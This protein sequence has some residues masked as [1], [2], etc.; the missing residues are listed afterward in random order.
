MFFFLVIS[1]IF[2][3]FCSW[4]KILIKKKPKLINKQ[5]GREAGYVQKFS[6]NT[7]TLVDVYL[8]ESNGILA[9]KIFINSLA[10][11]MALVDT[12]SVMRLFDLES[13]VQKDELAS[14]KRNDVWNVA[15]AAD[16]PTMFASM[17]KIKLHIFHD[18]HGEVDRSDFYFSYFCF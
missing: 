9:S 15:W 17:E 2:G 11:R 10:T 7:G 5:K 6:L 13:K 12:S 4:I 1:I 18:T 16:N 3:R 8:N 14:F